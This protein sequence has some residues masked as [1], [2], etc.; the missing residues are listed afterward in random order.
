MKPVTHILKGLLK[1][2]MLMIA[3]KLKLLIMENFKMC[4][5]INKI[6]KLYSFRICRFKIKISKRILFNPFHKIR[7]QSLTKK[8]ARQIKKYRKNIQTT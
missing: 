8:A 4:R 5:I 6:R 7:L 3:K 1:I 2:V